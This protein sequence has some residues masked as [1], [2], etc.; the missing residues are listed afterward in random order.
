MVLSPYYS[1]ALAASG[2]RHSSP[3]SVHSFFDIREINQDIFSGLFVMN[4]AEAKPWMNS[5][6]VIFLTFKDIDGL[7]FEDAIDMLSSKLSVLYQGYDIIMISGLKKKNT[8][9]P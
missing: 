9:S 7:S 4:D 2:R 8:L 5:Y 3:C 6:P 1:H